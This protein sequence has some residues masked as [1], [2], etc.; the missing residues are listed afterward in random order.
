MSLMDGT[1]KFR[2][3][4]HSCQ[5]SAIGGYRALIPVEFLMD[6]GMGGNCSC[7]RWC[8]CELSLHGGEKGREGHPGDS[9]GQI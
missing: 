1:R 5:D 4:A 3:K 6:R 7:K 2:A 8:R 9:S